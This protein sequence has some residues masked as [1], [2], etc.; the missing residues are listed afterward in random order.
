M[1]EEL[2][3]FEVRQSG[4]FRKASREDDFLRTRG[5]DHRLPFIFSLLECRFESMEEIQ[6]MLYMLG[7]TLSEQVSIFLLN[8]NLP[9]LS[10]IDST[11]VYFISY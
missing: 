6:A 3:H 11:G 8:E 4:D 2:L 10:R 9:M 7:R 5:D 1:V